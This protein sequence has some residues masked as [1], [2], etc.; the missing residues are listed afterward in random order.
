MT[1]TVQNVTLPI[2]IDSPD[3][4]SVEVSH[5]AIPGVGVPVG[6]AP[7]NVLVKN[8]NADY[9]TKWAVGGSGGGH[10]IQDEGISLTQRGILNFVG[11]SVAVTDGGASADSTI[12]TISGGSSK[13]RLFLSPGAAEV[14]GASTEPLL[15]GVAGTNTNWSELQFNDTTAQN[16]RWKFG[17]ANTIDYQ[18]GAITATITWKP[19][20]LLD[21]YYGKL[22]CYQELQAIKSIRH[23]TPLMHIQYHRP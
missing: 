13:M 18:G 1:V 6:G 23:M 2:T 19:L 10:T 7:G 21:Q 17:I 15:V 14:T 9:D 8:S 11:A 4:I 12:V 3:V 5:E 22:K 20:P 16:A